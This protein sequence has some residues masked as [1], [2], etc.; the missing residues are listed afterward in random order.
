[1][2]LKTSTNANFDM[3]AYHE[4]QSVLDSNTA[5]FDE[6]F[7]VGGPRIDHELKTFID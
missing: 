4:I 1:M 7:A 5:S 2:T 3:K 6:I